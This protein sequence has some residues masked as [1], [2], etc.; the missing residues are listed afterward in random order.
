MALLFPVLKTVKSNTGLFS[1][2]FLKRKKYRQNRRWLEGYYM[3][4]VGACSNF[5][6]FP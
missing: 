6:L 2:I 5:V 4:P 1:N 3:E